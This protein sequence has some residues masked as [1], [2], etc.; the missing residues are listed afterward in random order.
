M[1]KLKIYSLVAFLL[2]TCVSLRVVSQQQQQKEERSSVIIRNSDVV[3]SLDYKGR[4][5]N[6][7]LGNVI[8]DQEKNG[9]V[10]TCDSA[11]MYTSDS[12][13]L[14]G[15]IEM[16]QGPSTIRC[17]KM[18]YDGGW[19][20]VR[21]NVVRMSRGNMTLLTQYF[22]YNINQELGIYYNGGTVD[23]D[24]EILESDR[25]YYYAQPDLFMFAG[26]VAMK[27]KE[28]TIASDTMQ[29][30]MN[31]EDILFLGPTK[32]WQEDNFLS[33][34]YGWQKKTIGE[35]FF[36][37]NVY[38]NTP[39]KEL[40][41][42][43]LYYYQAEDRGLL[44]GN[45]QLVDTVQSSMAFGDEGRFFN[46]PEFAELYKNPSV[47]YYSK[48]QSDNEQGPEQDIA[49][50]ESQ[51]AD[52]VEVRQPIM[53]AESKPII[54]TLFVVAD[55]I[56]SVA[57]PNPALYLPQHDS[58][59]TEQQQPVDSVY[60]QIYAFRNVRAYRYDIQ[61]VCDSMVFNT[62]DSVA[63][64]Y[65]NP[66]IWSDTTQISSDSIYITMRNGVLETADFYSSPFIAMKEDSIRF[67]QIKGRN[68]KAFFIDNTID[69]LEVYGN[70]QNIYYLREENKIVNVNISEGS[71]MTVYFLN[72]AVR[73]VKYDYDVD[74]KV[75]PIEKQPEENKELKG[76]NWQ[77]ARRPKSREELFTRYV[78][79]SQRI[80]MQIYTPPVF[81]ITT[82]LSEI[83]KKSWVHARAKEEQSMPS[84]KK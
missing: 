3:R 34:N 14:F 43:S 66:I 51:V 39:D 13:D 82:R 8:I 20:R 15:Q 67:S 47:A 64:M 6:R 63:K 21:G 58:I 53:V 23:R 69:R 17:E 41:T 4:T 46:N 24:G 45:I 72:R 74:T 1:T 29:Y 30:N 68:M 36:T 7:L 79:P 52:D 56:R 80:Q 22:D 49:V 38:A 11:Y 25:G 5:I 44:Y 40:W 81:P 37:D 10:V 71:N 84:I 12:L 70:A 50:T 16:F 26:N 42:D 2:L 78:H 75:Y 27:N 18:T 61:S 60:R 31:T 62:R 32:I 73:R 28:Y 35:V 76:M 19:A 48:R 54:D 77:E 59:S 57:Y 55:T 83:E 33:A 9:V 65:I